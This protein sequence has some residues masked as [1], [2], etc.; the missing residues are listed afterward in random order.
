MWRNQDKVEAERRFKD[1]EKNLSLD[2]LVGNEILS[3]YPDEDKMKDNSLALV[4]DSG[5]VYLVT[6]VN[7]TRMRAQFS[8][9]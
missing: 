6:K 8:T 2:N 5:T 3:E 4:N 7:G 9:F 1:L